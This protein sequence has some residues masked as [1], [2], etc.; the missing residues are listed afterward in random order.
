ME[1]AVA[2]NDD[3]DIKAMLLNVM[4]ARNETQA[5]HDRFRLQF[6]RKRKSKRII[7]SF[8]GSRKRGPPSGCPECGGPGVETCSL[9]M[10]G[11]AGSKNLA[12]D[13]SNE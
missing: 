7:I 5:K 3:D 11:S 12:Y 10:S 1:T 2:A 13:F 4:E 6:Q 9:S 8:N